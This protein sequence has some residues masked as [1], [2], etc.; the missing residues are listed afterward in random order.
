MV[1]FLAFDRAHVQDVVQALWLDGKGLQHYIFVSTD[2]VYM[3][4]A[5]SVGIIRE[6]D[7]RL[8]ST[9]AEQ[10]IVASRSKYQRQYG[11]N[12]FRCEKFLVRAGREHGFPFTALR[13]PDV[14]GPYDNLTGFLELRQCLLRRQRVGL[15]IGRQVAAG[16]SHRISVVFAADVARAIRSCVRAHV[17]VHGVALNICCDETPTYHAFVCMVH[18]C[19]RANATDIDPSAQE[20]PE[21][22]PASK[23]RKS[24]ADVTAVGGGL[25]RALST[26]T[27]NPNSQQT[28]K[29]TFALHTRPQ[30]NPG[31]ATKAQRPW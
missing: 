7:A 29:H 31:S 5:P 25:T 13:L 2:S 16:H 3:V 11:G 24:C 20:K 14:I 23:K 15:R 17:R 22:A 18:A 27:G 4:C 10:Q 9:A 19:L 28:N 8:P 21:G 1:D 30:V 6:T 12:K 26:L